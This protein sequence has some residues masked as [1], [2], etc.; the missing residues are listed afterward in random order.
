[1]GQLLPVARKTAVI[2]FLFVVLLAGGCRGVSSNTG[3]TGATPADTDI[4]RLKTLVPSQ[5]HTMADVGYHWTNLFFAAEQRNWPL[6]EFY[7]NE[8][9]QHIEWTIKIRPI[10]KDAEGRD[11][12]LQAIFQ[13]VDS[14]AFAA[15][16]I[17]IERKDSAQF[18]IA[19]KGAL[20][21]CYSCHKSSGKPYLRP[22]V[23]TAP[24]QT[25]IDFSPDAAT[26][27]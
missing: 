14:S 7:F 8:A 12:D 19:Y 13:A 1:M 9:R 24:A 3:S 5:S 11:V 4:D 6:A 15:V 17:A 27:W 10:R 22:I 21:G 25:I 18:A 2:A 23:P 26:T 20:D 16:K